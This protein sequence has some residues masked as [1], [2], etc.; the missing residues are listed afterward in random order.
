M[1]S[2]K[3]W[4]TERQLTQIEL[5]EACGVPRWAIQLIESGCRLPDD[6]E[7]RLL[8][9][10]LGIEAKRLREHPRSNGPANRETST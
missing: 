4:R 5:Q 10:T 2:L 1:N 9:N 7:L 3:F 6:E 8:A